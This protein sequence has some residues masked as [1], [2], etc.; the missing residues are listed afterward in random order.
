MDPTILYILYHPNHDA[1]KVGIGD[2]AG[3]RFK[4]HRTKGWELVAYWYFQ[5]RR[6]ARRV[7]S[8]VLQTLRDRYGHFLDKG[9]MPYGGYTETFNARKIKKK[10]LIRMVNRAIKSIPSDYSSKDI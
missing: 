2:I 8:I 4:A 5:N 7:E 9:D 3:R 1:I 6:G 10:G